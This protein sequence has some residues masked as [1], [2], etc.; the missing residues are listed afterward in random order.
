M[1]GINQPIGYCTSRSD[2]T[3]QWN[4]FAVVPYCKRSVM[5]VLKRVG[6]LFR[7]GLKAQIE[8]TRQTWRVKHRAVSSGLGQARGGARHRIDR[9]GS[10]G[11]FAPTIAFGYREFVSHDR[12]DDEFVVGVADADD[13]PYLQPKPCLRKFRGGVAELEID[14]I[15]KV[16]LVGVGRDEQGPQFE[17][18][19]QKLPVLD[20]EGQIK[21]DFPP[22]GHAVGEFRRA[23]YA[24]M[25]NEATG[26]RRLLEAAADIVEMLLDREL[27]GRSNARIVDLDFVDGLGRLPQR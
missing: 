26:K 12:V 7:V 23:V 9:P 13:G 24:M 14:A 4:T 10:A 22:V 11:A 16:A 18:V 3:S 2:T 15:E 20:G 19:R 8:R 6:R 5:R 21:S 17:G 1:S 25:G 27:A